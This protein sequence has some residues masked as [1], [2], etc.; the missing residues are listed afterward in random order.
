MD[1]PEEL[2]GTL[3][4][5]E[6]VRGWRKQVWF[7]LL[8]PPRSPRPMGLVSI[9]MSINPFELYWLVAICTIGLLYLIGAPPPNSVRQLLPDLAVKVWA[10]NLGIGGV[11]ALSGGLFRRQLAR[12][13]AAY[14][15]GWALIGVATMIYGLAILIQF[16]VTG[17]YPALA[18]LFWALACLTRVAQVQQFFRLTKQQVAEAARDE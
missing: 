5:L 10:A 12:G 8:R 4:R 1:R 7:W 11:V 14:Q 13:L 3:A 2:A 18:N 16:P 15:F 17:I 6:Q 9:Q